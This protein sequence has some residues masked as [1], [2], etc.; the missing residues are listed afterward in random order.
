VQSIST[1]LNS[2]HEDGSWFARAHELRLW[3]VRCD[4]NVR[5]PA[6]T[7]VPKLEFHADNHS[8]WPVLIDAHTLADDGWQVRA[9]AL[10]VDW[11]RR[12]EAFAK[13]GVVQ[14]PV[15]ASIGSTGF[16]GFRATLAAVLAAMAEPLKGL[17]VV[18]AP[19]IVEQA[20]LF[21][22]GLLQLIADPGLQRARWVV[23]VDVD[24]P[25]TRALVDALADDR[26]LIGEY[27]VDDAE[28]KRDLAAMLQPAD[29]ARFGT[30]F[31]VGVEPPR[32]ID[33]PP[34]L[35]PAQKEAALRAAGI[36]P[37]MLT[38]APQI[39]ASLLGA[40]L[41]MKDGKPREAIGQQRA[42]RDLCGAV[43]LVE[44][45]VITRVGLASYLSGL[46]QRDEAK[47]ELVEATKQARANGLLRAE[48]QAHLALGL[49][50]G[51][52]RAY[53]AAIQSYVDAANTAEAGKEPTLAIE[54]WR[55]AGQ[56]SAQIGQD[57]VA[58]D[59]L[60]QALRVA[61]G[62]PADVQKVSSASEAARQLAVL[63]ER[64]GM[65][66]QAASL[67]DQADA[68]EAGKGATHA[69]Q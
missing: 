52:D 39:R 51:L 56:L 33:A 17:V 14:K 26:R 25:L 30:A 44:M 10:A 35:P 24:V 59:A 48:S 5:K 3:L 23:V 43:G 46:D 50:H 67:Y 20:E 42:A 60:R 4:A 27:R 19:T 13:E 61:T 16:A 54:S 38:A 15:V 6:I 65:A 69:G 21:E 2:L 18:L 57:D 34:P 53:P 64:H 32:R 37:A 8:A 9:N 28:Q 47:R 49:L 58:A 68:I 45:Q 1:P 66:A 41:A 11:A 40:A 36:D 29:P 31:P 12:V 55:M 63:C 62:E 22:A 7:L